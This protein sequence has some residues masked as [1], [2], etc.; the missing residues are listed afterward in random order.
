MTK[1]LPLNE[2]LDFFSNHFKCYLGINQ[3]IN[4]SHISEI[5]SSFSYL[6]K[7]NTFLFK[8]DKIFDFENELQIKNETNLI[9]MRATELKPVKYEYL[10][11]KLFIHP[12]DSLPSLSTCDWND[13]DF[14]IQSNVLFDEYVFKKLEPPYDTDCR[15]YKEKTRAECLNECFIR[16]Q[17]M[18]KKCLNNEEFLMLFNI[19][20][21]QTESDIPFCRPNEK[22]NYS[23]DSL[24]I[25]YKEYKVSYEE[26]ILII[27]FL[28]QK[29]DNSYTVDLD[30]FRNYYMSIIYTPNM[31]FMQYIIGVV[32]LMSL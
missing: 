16:Y 32:N 14:I 22:Q 28:S 2:E 5:V 7:C 9:T 25:C 18:S 8:L 27:E 4:C 20:V 24:N 31:L 17:V 30:F 3:T 15:I 21:N 12:S 11:N 10:L 13:S 29:M 23:L 19:D 1:T 6:G 26:Q